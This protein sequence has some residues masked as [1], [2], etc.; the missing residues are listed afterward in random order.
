MAKSLRNKQKV[1]ARR[2]KRTDSHYAVRESERLGRISANLM[3]K[4]EGSKK[5]TRKI[6]WLGDE[7]V[8]KAE[9]GVDEEGMGEGE[10]ME[11]DVEV[12]AEDG[13]YLSSD[14]E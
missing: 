4:G 6:D 5:F 11:D 3:G 1:A 9:E 7:E 14:V 8:K 12:K 13:E 2:Q 10:K